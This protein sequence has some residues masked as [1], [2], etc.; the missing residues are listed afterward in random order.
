MK[1]HGTNKCWPWMTVGFDAM[2]TQMAT[3]MSLNQEKQQQLKDWMVQADRKTYVYGYTDLLKLDLREDLVKISIPVSILA[4]AQPYGLEMA[5]HTYAEQYKYLKD[6][7]INF[8]ADA[9]HF[10]MYDSPQWFQEKLNN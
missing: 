10:I 1:V 6:Y 5:E 3:G 7:D 2:A 4:A 8:A 9:A